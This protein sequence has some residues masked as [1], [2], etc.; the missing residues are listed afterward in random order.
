MSAMRSLLT[1]VCRLINQIVVT[2][3]AK[4][5]AAPPIALPIT[6]ALVTLD[7]DDDVVVGSETLDDVELYMIQSS[8][9]FD[10]AGSRQ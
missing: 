8:D 3:N 7:L 9:S 1:R 6:V 2:S 5:T 4:T 10:I